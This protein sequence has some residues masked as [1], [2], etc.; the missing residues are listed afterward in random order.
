VRTL[1]TITLFL[2]S[3]LLFLVEPMVAKMI[4]PTFGG[5]PAVWNA[6]MVFFQ[7]VLL[8]G[9]LYA[10]LSTKALGA[11]RQAWIHVVV[12]LVPL[13][14]LPLAIPAWAPHGAKNPI[15]LLLALL[16]V[17]VGLPFFVL[18][19]GA[20]LI[21]RWFADTNDPDARDPYFL[22]RASNLGSMVGLLG[23]PALY[24]RDFTLKQQTLYWSCGYFA[25]VLLVACAVA[26][27][28][29]SPKPQE[30]K[31]KPKD[32][33]A[34]AI[35]WPLRLKWIALAAVPS[36]LLLGVTTYLT[37]N[38]TPVPLLWVVPLAL[39]L[40]T[41]VIA[42]SK[43]PWLSGSMLARILPLIVAPMTIAVILEASDF[44]VLLACMHLLMFFIAALMCHT[45][46]AESRPHPKHL[47]EF[48]LWLS[49]GGML[50]GVFNALIAPVV[51]KTVAEYPIAI[52]L[53][54]FLRPKA[55]KVKG[56]PMWDY[57]YPALIGIGTAAVVAFC[58]WDGIG[59]S[60]KRT[61]ATI[62][63]PAILAFVAVDRPVRF[64]LTI[65]AVFFVANVMHVS[66]GGEVVLTERSFFGVDRVLQYRPVSQEEVDGRTVNRVYIRREFVH[67]TTLHGTQN[68]KTD[69]LRHTPLT[70]YYPTGPIGRLFKAYSGPYKK[71][72]VAL[73]GLGTGS[74]AAYGEP[75]QR[76]T[77]F[78]IDPVVQYIARDSG[79]FTYL[80]DSRAQV[81]IV[82]GDARLELAREPARRYGM[83]VL[84]AF[85]SDSIPV[86]LLTREALQMYLSKLT[87]DGLIVFHT[88]NRYLDLHGVLSN[89][90][91]SEGL[92]CMYADDS[93]SETWAQ[94]EKADGKTASNW[95]LM[96]R[97]KDA[98]SR[99]ASDGM[100]QPLSPDPSAPTW[101]DD[102]SNV[103]SVFRQRP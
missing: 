68:F 43:K 17:A 82:L 15:L 27:L 100:W 96:A 38:L 23:Y 6:C 16:A 93:D 46:L 76:L 94:G 101:T 62:G 63:V 92:C 90:A 45:L 99:V 61:L 49:V 29:R 47:T 13:L 35:S 74:L 98:C 97:T 7:T 20:P 11:R 34:D 32:E 84:D 40:L 77:F 9:Y 51:F 14:V 21:Q 36:S 71:S 28:W 26:F 89:L 52:V 53:A 3:A 102:Y 24:E 67:G 70:Y 22:Y 87:D 12:M 19:A 30:E 39:Y 57:L 83:I 86:H 69:Q 78:E 48:Y 1:Y 50:G 4:L 85:S 25:L 80:A 56:T 33:P 54:C 31:P 66:S 44:F 60:Q 88:S 8:L 58:Y 95:L 42:F 75:G 64:G 37:T 2:C 5:S 73:V 72:D 103:L 59:P 79:L 55:E 18:S 65:A 81:R 10:H 91:A 41:F